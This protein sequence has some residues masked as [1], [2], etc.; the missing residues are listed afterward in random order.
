[1]RCIVTLNSNRFCFLFVCFVLSS[2]HYNTNAQVRYGSDTVYRFSSNI[3]RNIK[4]DSES[5]YSLAAV[6]LSFIGA[7][8]Q[9][10]SFDGKVREP[11]G[12][13]NK[14][15]STY[16]ESFMGLDARQYILSKAEDEQIIIIN[17]AHHFPYHRTFITSLLKP[18]YEKGFRYY[19]AETLN[20]GDSTIVQLG[21]P[22][23]TSGYYSAEPQFGNLIREALSLGYEIFPYEARSI[24][25]ISDPKQ[26]E[27]E[28]ARNILQ[29]LK[30]EPS[31]KILIHAGYDHIREDSIGSTWEKAMAGRLKELS[32]IDPFTINQE[33]L[34]ERINPALENP[35]YLMADDISV[36]TVFVNSEGIPFS[37]PAGTHYYDVRLAH[38]RTKYIHDRPNWIFD[39]NRNVKPIYI[40]KSELSV[41]FPCLIQVY[42]SSE[43]INVA[44]PL[45][46]VEIADTQKALALP[47]GD[48]QVFVRGDHSKTKTF[49]LLVK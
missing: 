35:F 16:F 34:T 49:P 26:R 18:L 33:V 1:M 13:I 30:E 40:D 25:T 39:A 5:E 47:P 42:K 10:L 43:D 21:Y 22:T 4:E 38:P 8:K 23:I 20:Y 9:V 19:A 37:G 6:Y 32:G 12:P 45:D 28:Q 15:D 48:Y 24:E 31:A 7:Y 36:P 2:F 46:V 27:S 14:S 44:V 3:L 41:G 17:E 29:I 11:Y